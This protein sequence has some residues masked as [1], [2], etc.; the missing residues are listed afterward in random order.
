MMFEEL[1]RALS[2][3]FSWYFA[4]MDGRMPAKFLIAKRTKAEPGGFEVLD[5]NLRE[6]LSLYN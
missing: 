2:E 5:R 1:R 4:V 3:D 6:F